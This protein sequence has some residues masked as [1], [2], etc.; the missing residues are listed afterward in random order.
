MSTSR[1]LAVGLGAAAALAAV[2]AQAEVRTWRMHDDH[3]LGTSLD[4]AVVA[5]SQASAE[6]AAAA[7]RAEIDRLDAI[8]SGW[9]DDSELAALNGARQRVVSPDLFAVL[10]AAET[11][12]ERTGGAFDARIGAT[13]AALRRGEMAAHATPAA[14]TLDAA[15]RT[16]TRPEGVTFDLDGVAKGYV[17]DKALEAARAASPDVA[18]V[19]VDIGGDLRCWGQGPGGAWRVGVAEACETADNAAPVTVLNADDRAVAYSGRGLRD[20]TVDGRVVS[21]T[22][23]PADGRPVEETHAVC[24]TAAKAADADALATAMGVMDVDAAIAL[25]DRTPGV[26]ALVFRAN[27]DRRASAGWQRLVDTRD[28]PRA[29]LI[30]VA[31]GPVWPKGFEVAVAYEVP[32]IAVGN[33]RAPYLAIWVTDENKQLVRVLTMLGDNAKWIPDNY[34]FWRRYGRK[35]PEVASTARPTRA[36]GKYSAS[37]D[38]RDQAGKPVGQGTYT[39][40]V[41]AVREHGG[42]SYVSSDLVVGAAA[43][44][45]SIPGKEELGGVVLR[46][47]KKK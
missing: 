32:K 1:I 47:G 30:R 46:Y 34:V 26:E 43:A 38:G 33:Y 41:E 21:A 4:L 7:A 14:V 12:R 11:W 10:H 31:D 2:P 6:M 3:V 17:I 28:G 29:Q 19:M 8:L 39:I 13:T 37:W 24:V 44:N 25:A 9:R 20:L 5:S 36:P 42:H 22:L 35:T 16:V 45:V 23:N 18:G 15:T 40:H 27:G